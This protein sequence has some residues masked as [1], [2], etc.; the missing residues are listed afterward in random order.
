MAEFTKEQQSASYHNRSLA[1]LYFFGS[2]QGKKG[3]CLHHADE[4]LRDKDP[5]RYI[6]WRIEDLVPMSKAEHTSLH[7]KGNQNRLGIPCSEE[8]K[9]KISLANTGRKHTEE[10]KKKMSEAQKGEGNP[11]FG[12]HCSEETKRKISSANKGNKS[13]FGKHHTDEAKQKMSEAH[14]GKETWN[15]GISHSTSTKAK[16]SVA[17]KGCCWFNNGVKSVLA[18]DCPNGFVKGRLPFH[19]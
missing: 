15:K 4:T 17:K 3:W 9:A 18:R 16:I 14:K 6:Q 12:K 11:H 1:R 10:A 13:F 8:A 5:E 19:K 7:Q 2:K